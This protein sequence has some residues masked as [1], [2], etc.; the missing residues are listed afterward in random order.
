MWDHMYLLVTTFKCCVTK[1]DYDL[2]TQKLNVTNIK[3]ND[4]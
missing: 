2:V 4:N 3:V 1:Y